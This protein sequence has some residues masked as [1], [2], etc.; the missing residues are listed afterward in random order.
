MTLL[1]IQ[2]NSDYITDES[3]EN[4]NLI[5]ISNQCIAHVNT[6]ARTNLPM[7]ISDNIQTVGYKPLTDSWQ[8]RLIE[9]YITWTIA[10]NDD[11]DTR[12]WHYDR[13]LTALNDFMNSDGSGIIE[14]VDEHGNIVTNYSG[15]FGRIK[16]VNAKNVFVD[17]RW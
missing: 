10:S 7:M 16:T 1:E 6:K 13:F 5:G 17:M 3:M 14:E 2:Q 4:V 15:N 12:A 9:P 11:A 8:L